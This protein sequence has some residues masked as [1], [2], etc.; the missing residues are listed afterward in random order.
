M[1][2]TPAAEFHID[3]ALVA[4]LL[5]EQHPDLADLP[6]EVLA[7]GWDNAMFRLGTDFVA[8]LPRRSVAVPLIQHEQLWLPTLL[9]LSIAI[10]APVRTGTPGCGYPWPWS[11]LPWISG[12]AADLAPPTPDQ[13]ADLA[14]FLKEL[15]RPPAQADTLPKNPHRGCPLAE[16]VDGIAPRIE[17]L[18]SVT[19]VIT[20]TILGIWK[21]ALAAAP[22]SQTVWLHG[23]LHARNV[24]VDQGRISAIIDWGD[25]CTGDAATDLMSIWA[26]FDDPSVRQT[27]LH[28][29]GA[30]A[31]LIARSKG[32]VIFMAAILLD[33]GLQDN[34]RH[35]K[36]GTDMFRRL[37]EDS[38]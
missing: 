32:W 27:A 37:E 7:S 23:D 24:V 1:P 4:S 10:P 33:T 2:G 3:V 34:P 25:I 28:A 29:Y 12:E 6:I 15:H 9:P 20:P 30:D 22:S 19:D 38:W 31:D 13:A 26:L 8:R 5:A 16:K 35:A 11:V 17:R 36:M 18:S 21:A 14:R